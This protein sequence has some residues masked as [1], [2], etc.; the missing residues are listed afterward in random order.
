M[1]HSVRS[2]YRIL[3]LERIFEL[4]YDLDGAIAAAEAPDFGLG[5][6]SVNAMSETATALRQRIR[7]ARKA[8][9]KQQ[10]VSAGDWLAR[11]IVERW[12]D[13]QILAYAAAGP[14][15][16]MSLLQKLWDKGQVVALPSVQGEQLQW[17]QV[18]GPADLQAGYRGILEPRPDSPHFTLLEKPWLLLVPGVAFTKEGRRL[19]QGGG[20]YDRELLRLRE[21]IRQDG[22]EQG[23]VIGVAFSCQVVEAIPVEEHD[24]R[25]DEVLVVDKT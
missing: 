16:T 1:T 12:P 5:T 19:G 13:H 21:N 2:I 17:H 9:T 18:M 8:L 6:G 14:V 23:R 7:A 24:Q 11:E 15:P 22:G 10:R 3:K 4:E 25:V 20:F